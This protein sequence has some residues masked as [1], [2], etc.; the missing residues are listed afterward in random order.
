MYIRKVGSLTVD[1]MSPPKDKFCV[2]LD[3]KNLMEDFNKISR[4]RKDSTDPLSQGNLVLKKIE[5]GKMVYSSSEFDA[6]S[7]VR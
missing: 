6:Q 1:G 2:T 3:P 5:S 7:T 4:D